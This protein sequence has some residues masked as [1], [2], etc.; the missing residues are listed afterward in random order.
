MRL[1]DEAGALLSQHQHYGLL[2]VTIFAAQKLTV[3]ARA[4]AACSRNDG[5]L[6][7]LSYPY[8]AQAT[9]LLLPK[10]RDVSLNC[11]KPCEVFKLDLRVLCDS[12][13]CL[14]TTTSSM[15][16]ASFLSDMKAAA[17]HKTMFQ[18]SAR[19]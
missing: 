18:D 10:V 14:K 17:R 4:P 11:A 9:P 7:A 2:R 19:A 5:A 16:L 13:T 12:I 6:Q 1:G 15:W 3:N 8:S